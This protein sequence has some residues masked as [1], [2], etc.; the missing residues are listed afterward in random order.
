MYV[1]SIPVTIIGFSNMQFNPEEAN[2]ESILGF[3]TIYMALTWFAMLYLT[4]LQHIGIS[5]QYFSLVEMKEAKGLM[6]KIA[7]IQSDDSIESHLK[8][9]DSEEDERY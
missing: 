7:S 4:V 1:I 3:M 9:G 2:P 6:E 5:L 8:T